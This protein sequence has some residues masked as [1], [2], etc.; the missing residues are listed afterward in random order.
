MNV[1]ILAF[2]F[3]PSSIIVSDVCETKW[4]LLTSTDLQGILCRAVDVKSGKKLCHTVP[5]LGSKTPSHR[6][7][8]ALINIW[9][10]LHYCFW[11][12]ITL[13]LNVLAKPPLPRHKSLYRTLPLADCRI[14]YRGSHSLSGKLYD[15]IIDLLVSQNEHTHNKSACLPLRNLPFLLEES[16]WNWS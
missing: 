2:S 14:E 4:S 11:Q 15:R 13:W 6:I 5:L 3:S 8:L 12:L 1:L 9:E 16:K 7:K 10:L